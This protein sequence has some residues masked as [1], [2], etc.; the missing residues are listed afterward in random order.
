MARCKAILAG[1]ALLFCSIT[2]LMASDADWAHY[3]LYL[4]Q[5]HYPAALQVLEQMAEQHDPKAMLTLAQWYRNGTGGRKDAVKSRQLMQ[6][7]AEQGQPEAQYQLG[8][9]TLKGVGGNKNPILARAWLEKAAHQ[10]HAKARQEIAHW[11]APAATSEPRHSDKITSVSREAAA[12]PNKTVPPELSPLQ[13]RLAAVQQSSQALLALRRAV[14][15][16]DTAMATALLNSLTPQQQRDAWGQD[17]EG[18]TL[19]TLAA[20]QASAEMLAL[21]LSHADQ[22]AWQDASGRNALFAALKGQRPD[23]VAL[24]LKRSCDAMQADAK[25]MTPLAWAIQTGHPSASTLLDATQVARWQPAWLTIAALRNDL[26][27]ALKLLKAGIS[28]DYTDQEGRDALWY[29][30]QQ[31]NTTLLKALMAAGAQPSLTDRA[32]DTALHVASQRGHIEIVS[33]L[34]APG[35]SDSVATLLKQANAKGSAALH[36][37]SAAGQRKVVEILLHAGADIDPRDHAGNTPL[38]V[39]A[40]NHRNEVISLLLQRGAELDKR[41]NNKKTALDI[42]EQLGYQE[43]STLLRTASQ[44]Q[45]VMS[46]FQ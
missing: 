32:G 22:R 30:A 13:Q 18:H 29:A 37:A 44:Q 8:L 12:R 42:A 15:K 2:P 34:L 38:I 19:I 21:L 33:T 39:A 17:A 36:L 20:Q 46:I 25:G 45:G 3:Q 6:K 11:Q 7:A 1:V 5:R 16:S 23:N 28:A 43:L 27:L 9:M 35:K 10:D 24:L 4:K 14:L 31:G 40:I 26:A 41:N